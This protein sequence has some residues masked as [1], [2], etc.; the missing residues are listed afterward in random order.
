[1][2]AEKEIT[3]NTDTRLEMTPFDKAKNDSCPNLLKFFTETEKTLLDL[4]IKEPDTM[5]RDLLMDRYTN[6]KPNFKDFGEAVNFI[7]NTQQY[8]NRIK[9]LVK[10]E[11]IMFFKQR[12]DLEG[13]STA[14]QSSADNDEMSTENETDNTILNRMIYGNSNQIIYGQTLLL[15]LE[16]I[17]DAVDSKVCGENDDDFEFRRQQGAIE[18]VTSFYHLNCYR[19]EFEENE[20]SCKK[21]IDKFLTKSFKEAGELMKQKQ[22]KKAVSKYL[23]GVFACMCRFHE[24]NDKTINILYQPLLDNDFDEDVNDARPNTCLPASEADIHSTSNNVEVIS[25]NDSY[26]VESSSEEDDEED[27]DPDEVAPDF[28]LL[29]CKIK[30]I[31]CLLKD[32]QLKRASRY[33]NHLVRWMCQKEFNGHRGFYAINYTDKYSLLQSYFGEA[34]CQLGNSRQAVDGCT[35]A[36]EQYIELGHNLVNFETNMFAVRKNFFERLVDEWDVSSSLNIDR[37]LDRDMQDCEVKAYRSRAKIIVDANRQKGMTNDKTQFVVNDIDS[38]LRIA[39][40]GDVIFLEEGTYIGSKVGKKKD[41]SQERMIEVLKNVEIIGFQTSRVRLV[42][43]VVKRSQGK[44]IFRN[45]TFQVGKDQGSGESIYAMSGTTQLLDCCIK[46]PANTAIHVINDQPDKET[47]LELDFC[48]IDGMNY[49][50]RILSFEGFHPVINIKNCYVSDSLSFC[51]VLAP[52]LKCAV[53]MTVLNSLFIH[54]QDGIK[55]ILHHES[56]GP[57]IVQV[58]GCHFELSAYRTEDGSPSIAFCQTAGNVILENNYIN[59]LS[60]DVLS[61]G[62]SLHSLQS[63]KLTMNMIKS[64]TEVPRQFSISQGIMITECLKTEIESTEI[65]GMRVGIKLAN[66]IEHEINSVKIQDCSIQCCSLGLLMS[67]SWN[68]S[69][70][71]QQNKN[72]KRKPSPSSE[73]DNNS[74][75]N[76]KRPSEEGNI[77]VLNPSR[78]CELLSKQKEEYVV[79][80]I[81]LKMT[82]CLFDT[83]YYGVMNETGKG[84]LCLA[85]NT[86]QNIPKAVLLN[87]SCLDTDKVELCFN[88]FQLTETFDCTDTNLD[89]PQEVENLRRTL[90]IHFSVYENLPHRIAYEAKDYFVV[91]SHFDQAFLFQNKLASS[92]SATSDTDPG[93]ELQDHQSN[94]KRMV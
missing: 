75:D 28:M 36:I 67:E 59:M 19:N 57:P 42:G 18:F 54:V 27:E 90:Y 86:F 83:S 78:L 1:M 29:E 89:D 43:S 41:G 38:A 51:V 64:T 14:V 20:L 70:S 35:S 9:N 12:P 53:N 34:E 50:E 84:Q 13:F 26:N 48:V 44:V 15:V 73:D 37:K 81:Y 58:R 79:P 72:S 31:E 76:I 49:C 92:F 4:D 10:Y 94:Y 80:N 52:E 71:V 46:S 16:K 3:P 65:N 25:E 40:D 45:I 23:D 91:S 56:P 82:G 17:I 87:H 6:H 8:T 22:Y 68:H 47:V 63:A 85:Q 77:L 32:K 7:M 39:K 74:K 5:A 21:L 61:T 30:L 93:E 2:M 60:H 69:E 88:E 11:R 33:A 66:K 55:V 62:F 24:A